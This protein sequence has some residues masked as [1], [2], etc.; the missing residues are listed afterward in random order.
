MCNVLVSSWV[1]SN[2]PTAAPKYNLMILILV[3]P[4]YLRGTVG[5]LVDSDLN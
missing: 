2:D 3:I 4:V 5:D 1:G